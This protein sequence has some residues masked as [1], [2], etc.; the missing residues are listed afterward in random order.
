MPASE[1]AGTK[2]GKRPRCTAALVAAVATLAAGCAQTGDFGRP[3]QTEPL[4][5]S[6]PETFSALAGSPARPLIGQT[7]VEDELLTRLPHF[8]QKETPLPPDAS[9]RANA[10]ADRLA[11]DLDLSERIWHLRPQLAE[12]ARIRAGAAQAF[13]RQHPEA[14]AMGRQRDAM[15]RAL[16]A[17]HCAR[18]IART[19]ANRH[20]LEELV[21]IAPEIEDVTTERRLL[22]LEE[23][24]PRLCAEATGDALP[25]GAGKTG[26]APHPCATTGRPLVI[27]N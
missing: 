6:L 17:E 12:K 11:I 26:P 22:A 21:L 20:A 27:K 9:A 15:D 2:G 18:L 7:A 14:A 5:G 16:L 23:R 19:R 10:I 25:G 8:R 1:R 13:G 4:L 24:L 3:R